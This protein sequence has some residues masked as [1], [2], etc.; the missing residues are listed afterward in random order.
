MAPFKYESI[1][2]KGPAFRLL[3]LLKGNI[4]EDIRCQLFHTR[5]H[6]GEFGMPYEA[7]S[8][9]WG[10][11]E[12]THR[13]II[14]GY[15]MS[16]THNLYLAMKHLR[17]E[18]NNRIL[19]ID[20]TCINQDNIHERGHQ[21]Q[22]M[23]AI[24]KEAEQVIIWLGTATN[25]TDLM[26]DSIKRLQEEAIKYPYYPWI[27]SDKRWKHY[28]TI[29]QSI[30]GYTGV[31]L[32]A[33]QRKGLE[34]LLG[35]SWFRRVWILQEVANAHTAVVVCGTKSV[36]ARIF[37]L[38]PR[39][40]GI[41]PEPHCQAVLDIF[42]GSARKHSW[43]NEKRDLRTLLMKFGKSEAT[44]TRDIIY[45]L[46]GISSDACNNDLLRADYSMSIQEVIQ[47][48][49]SFLL[50]FRQFDQRNLPR[51]TFPE[52]LQNLNSLSDV[53]LEWAAYN[54]PKE[55]NEH[56]WKLPF[57]RAKPHQEVI[58]SEQKRDKAQITE[59]VVKAVAA[60]FDKEVMTFL[61]D[62]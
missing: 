58:R 60:R 35:R 50:S 42:P 46:F 37:S 17:S 53:V 45:A 4:F 26:M 59:E 3:L 40:V 56:I 12:K 51:W 61:L 11:T 38:I 39:L 15:L 41:D 7:L 25:E 18:D 28:W 21:V 22:H 10:G 16:V 43:W 8:Y 20:A 48:T 27:H 33:L 13:I 57:R 36:S 55:M 9:T 32:D 1:D 31:Y 5:L 49:T 34:L 24:Y 23:A 52:F 62:Q 44:D 30:A 29:T 2:L 47:E 54:G 6:Q 19:W 14:D